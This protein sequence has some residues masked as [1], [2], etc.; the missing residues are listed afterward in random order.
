[1]PPCAVSPCPC[2]CRVAIVHCLLPC[3][4]ERRRVFTPPWVPL[5][6]ASRRDL[7][8]SSQLGQSMRR[9]S[10]LRG[11]PRGRRLNPGGPP[12]PAEH[13]VVEPAP[14]AEGVSR[15]LSLH[16]YIGAASLSCS[17]HCSRGCM[18]SGP[19]TPYHTPTNRAH[20]RALPFL[21]L[22]LRP[23]SLLRPL[24]SPAGDEIP[25]FGSSV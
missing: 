21:S 4:R 20:T 5:G 17:L 24:R 18:Q 19:P 12:A 8:R 6:T 2:V 9:I 22:A 11:G 15:I 25:S 13:N 14:P 16:S 3:L 10:L 1:M 23:S 7:R